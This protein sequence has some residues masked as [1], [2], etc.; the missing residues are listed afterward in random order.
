[1]AV[2]DTIEE[3]KLLQGQGLLSS[4]RDTARKA[5]VVEVFLVKD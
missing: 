2:L 1:V 3:G 5:L 4:S